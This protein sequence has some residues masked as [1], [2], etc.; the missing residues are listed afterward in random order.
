MMTVSM[1]ALEE[2]SS[3]KLK[4]CYQGANILDFGKSNVNGHYTEPYP[5][6]YISVE[7]CLWNVLLFIFISQ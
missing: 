6:D 5:S 3:E 1:H 4:G 2:S 7:I